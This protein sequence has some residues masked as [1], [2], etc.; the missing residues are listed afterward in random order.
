MSTNSECMFFQ[1]NQG[2]WYY[3]IEDANSME[4]AWDWREFATCYGPF[5]TKEQAN[6]HLYQNHANPGGAYIDKNPDKNDTV[7]QE[8]VKEAK[9]TKKKLAS[10]CRAW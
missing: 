1:W 9:N 10:S 2:E 8:F 4:N 3:V 5:N 6:E 7:L